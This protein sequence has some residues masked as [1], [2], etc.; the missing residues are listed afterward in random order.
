MKGTNILLYVM[1]SM[2]S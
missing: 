2:I 1:Q